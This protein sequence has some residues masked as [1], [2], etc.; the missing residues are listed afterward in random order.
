[1]PRPFD[2]Y[3]AAARF[4]GDAS[5]LDGLRSSESI[6]A[7]IEAF[8]TVRRRHSI[9]TQLLARAVR[10]DLRMVPG[11]AASF[12][13]LRNRLGIDV[14]MEAY[15]F[16]DASINAFV[17]R[18]RRHVFV[19]L[20]SAAVNGLQEAEL[21]FVIGHELGHAVFE[22]VDM[23]A[24][25]LLEMADLSPRERMRVRAW[26]RAAEISADRVGLLCCGS[27]DVAATAMFKTIS[28][29]VRPD[30]AVS[31]RE[32]ASQWELLEREVI[33][34]GDTDYWQLSHPF[35]P[36]RVKA[37]ILFAEFV[38]GGG[39]H[40]A[41]AGTIGDLTE[42]DAAVHQLLA[43]MDPLARESK[44]TR[45]PILVDFL[46]WGGLFIAWADGTID[47]QEVEKLN[48]IV[49]TE[50]VGEAVGERTPAAE[51]CLEQFK[52]SIAARR[53][54]LKSGEIYRILQG[55]ADVALADGRLDD[56]EMQAISVLGKAMGLNESACELFLSKHTAQ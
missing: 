51:E 15:V 8:D 31:A 44:E 11:V 49:S 36:L 12:Q 47:D 46:L 48:A 9:R 32:F 2:D 13:S 10:V 45:D 28:G 5:L 50:R 22:H 54:K 27:L 20:S 17:V 40:P 3:L 43:I 30:V 26:E 1:M 14:P 34:D 37:M 18:G 6:S 33:L 55:L 4:C 35:P 23:P 16:Q 7:H 25:Y 52:S 56:S 39:E 24:E 29:L 21:D 41:S 19:A 53:R 42:T 38:W